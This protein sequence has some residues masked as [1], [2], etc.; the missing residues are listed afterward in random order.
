[1]PVSKFKVT[2]VAALGDVRR[3]GRSLRVT[4]YGRPL[5]DVVPARLAETPRPWLGAVQERG[6]VAGD[7]V[8]PA[9]DWVLHGLAVVPNRRLRRRRST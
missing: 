9:S 3:T 5:V 4:R 1:M 7:L 2:C 6:R 8:A